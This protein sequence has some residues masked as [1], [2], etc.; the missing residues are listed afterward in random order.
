MISVAAAR[1]IIEQSCE[2]LTVVSM[3]LKD[4]LGRGLAATIHS[5]IDM[6]SF[7]QSAMD[8]YAFCFADWQPGL[9]LPVISEIQAGA[10]ADP[11]FQPQTATRIFTGAPLPGGTDTVVMQEH[12]TITGDGILIDSPALQCGSN[13]RLQGSEIKQGTIALAKGS[14]LTPTALGFLASIGISEAPVYNFPRVAII[15]TGNELQEPGNPLQY[16][17]VYQSNTL[18][19]QTALQQLHIQD[20]TV[21]KV[22]DDPESIESSIRKAIR[23]AD[24]LLL[25]G[26]VSVGKYDYVATALEQAGVQRH[27]HKIKQKPGRPLYFG[28]KDRTVIFGL[29]GNPASVTVCF[30]Q[31]VLKAIEKLCCYNNSLSA[32]LLLPLADDYT[33]P[34][35]LTHFLKAGYRQNEVQVL[36][37]QE[38]YRL[39]SFAQA[40]CLVEIPAEATVTAKGTLVKVHPLPI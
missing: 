1:Q 28:M 31:Y 30:Y 27:F 4:A 14:R 9:A 16:G 23:Q 19:L 7:H 12:T 20:I 18:I 35:G 32:E 36:Q 22:P 11:G 10:K 38:S 13:V 26:G 6:P 25:T 15:A 37:A 29:P 8:G 21:Y 39:S 24:L 2:P 40:N 33:K 34:A 17:K 5:P 3:A